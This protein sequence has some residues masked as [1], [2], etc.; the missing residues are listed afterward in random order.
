MQLQESDATG[1]TGERVLFS[2]IKRYLAVM[3]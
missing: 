3:H 1:M 2:G